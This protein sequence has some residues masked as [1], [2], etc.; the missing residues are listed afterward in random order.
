MVCPY[1]VQ[2]GARTVGS[3]IHYFHASPVPLGHSHGPSHW[4]AKL[5][6]LYGVALLV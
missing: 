1:L 5:L 3:M 4:Q 6:Y 2:P